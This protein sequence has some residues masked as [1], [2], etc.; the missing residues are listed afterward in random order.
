MRRDVRARSPH[1]RRAANLKELTEGRGADMVFV[2]TNAKG[3][4]EEAIRCSRPG[5]KI[6]L[7]AQTSDKERI[8]LSGASICVGRTVAA[9]FLQR[10][11]RHYRRNRRDLVFSGE[12]PLHLLISHRV[13]LDKIEFAFRLATHPGEFPGENPLENYRATTGACNLRAINDTMLAAVLYGKEHVQLE[14]VPVPRSGRAIFWC[15]CA[16]R[17][18]AAPTSRS[19]PRLSRAHDRAARCVRPRTGRRRDRGGRRSRVFKSASAWWP[20]IPRPA[21]QCFYCSRGRVNLCEDLLFNN[22]AYAEYIRIPARIVER[23]H[24]RDSAASELSD[25]ALAE[26]L[27]CVV[28]GLED[29]EM[30]RA[31][32]SR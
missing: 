7:F 30:K 18:P 19:S 15:A 28:K 29:V 24:L 1:G 16:P 13:P 32:R 10:F 22:G 27:A 26:P 12:L 23:Q 2:A 20:P 6:M 11:G 5:A 25:A 9:R 17:S 3:L 8:E 31:I 21:S 4:V 14:R